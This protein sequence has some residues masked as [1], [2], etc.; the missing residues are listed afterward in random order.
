MEAGRYVDTLVQEYRDILVG[1]KEQSPDALAAT[2]TAQA[3]WT[4]AGARV[5][6]QLVDD[7]GAFMLRN[8]LA[9]AEA[10]G[11]E[12]GDKNF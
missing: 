7:Y 1:M 3:D 11:K 12:D 9:L 5:L 4:E 2:L 10:F 8:A 6:I